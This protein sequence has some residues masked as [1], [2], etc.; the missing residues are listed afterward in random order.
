MIVEIEPKGAAVEIASTK[1]GLRAL[2]QDLVPTGPVGPAGDTADLTVE[3]P[4]QL[5]GGTLS[6]DT[7]QLE[8]DI[9]ATA[10]ITW[11]PD[12]ETVGLQTDPLSVDALQVSGEPAQVTVQASNG[13]ADPLLEMKDGKANSVLNHQFRVPGFASAPTLSAT[14]NDST[15]YTYTVVARTADGRRTNIAPEAV[16]TGPDSLNTLVGFEDG[17]IGPWSGDASAVGDRT[18]FG[19]YSLYVNGSGELAEYVP[20]SG[21]DQPRV[22]SFWYQETASGSTGFGMSLRDSS[23]NEL[24]KV[25]SSNPIREVE[26]GGGSTGLGYPPSAHNAWHRVRI[27][28][29]WSAG[30]FDVQFHDREAGTFAEE[31]GLPLKNN[32]D[33]EKLVLGDFP[34][35]SGGGSTET[36]IDNVSTATSAEKVDV[37]WNSRTNAT[38]YVVLRKESGSWR[39]LLQTTSTSVEDVGYETLDYTIP[40]ENETAELENVGGFLG[41]VRTITDPSTFDNAF[42]I[43]SLAGKNRFR[44][45]N[46]GELVIKDDND[47]SEGTPGIHKERADGSARILWESGNNLHLQQSTA[48]AGLYMNS[49]GRSGFR[50]PGNNNRGFAFDRPSENGGGKMLFINSKK[51]QFW[52]RTIMQARSGQSGPILEL[53]DSSGSALTKVTPTGR[54]DVSASEDTQLIFLFQGGGDGLYGFSGQDNQIFS[55]TRQSLTDS[56]SVSINAFGD[57]GIAANTGGSN[58][59]ADTDHTAV[60]RNTSLGLNRAPLDTL[61]IYHPGSG[62]GAAAIRLTHD[63]TDATVWR[64]TSGIGGEANPPLGIQADGTLRWELQNGGDLKFRTAGQG[65]VLTSPD[66]SVT[67]RVKLD[68]SGS[69]VVENV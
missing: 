20:Y 30:T 41:R 58:V 39:R 2:S 54:I 60:F 11:D 37:S 3:S 67:K 40:T 45:T 1:V 10:P 63:N 28:F 68:N 13:Q 19:S 42:R 33:L 15:D 50:L 49:G 31:T 4:L 9:T 22:V 5:S 61:D 14:S 36:W 69:L 12:T 35:L 26:Y 53:Q 21:G 34:G 24:L 47:T 62:A 29:D 55:F 23:G 38:D 7:S 65:I 46:A 43:D 52:G 48:R 27:V 8:T 16:V 57:V 59:G 32:T 66:G 6:I 44:I 56:G 51:S 18:A 17:S 25:G 64:F